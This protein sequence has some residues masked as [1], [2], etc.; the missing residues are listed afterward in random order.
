[1]RRLLIL[2]PIVL[3]ALALL[4]WQ[5]LRTEPFFV[6]G[7]IETDDIR[8][9]SRVGGRVKDVLVREGQ[10][11]KVAQSLVQL[12]PYDLEAQLAEAHARRA[13][14][15]HLLERL[16]AG[17]RPEEIAAARAERDRMAANLQKL[18]AGMRPLE[19]D[20]LVDRLDVAKA[21]LATAQRNYDRVHALYERGQATK[22]EFDEVGETLTAA[23]ARES[24]AR[25]ELELAQEGTR[26]EEIAEARAARDRAEA[27]LQLLEA[28]YRVEEIRQ[29]EADVQAADAAIAAIQRRLDELQIRA[30]LDS[31]VEVIELLPGDLIPPNAPVTTLVTPQRLYVR[32]YVPENRL[33]VQVGRM[34]SLRVDAFPQ[35]RF[36]GRVTYV[37]REAEFTPANV[38][39]PEERVKQVFRIKV[40]VLEGLDLL[41]AGM[42]ADVFLDEHHS[43]PASQ[44]AP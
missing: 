22:Q 21:E 7:I 17:P 33:D 25:H 11:V 41:R 4:Y 16:R 9:G 14:Q 38:Q 15:A 40:D 19:I 3:I 30:P 2:I 12:E 35:R 23:R 20:I 1:M 32:S 34:V 27:Q 18:Q 36:A 24:L 5:Q 10:T 39:T 43:S 29:A 8:V 31:V 28:G 37:S 13:A 44:A 6:S 26:A 42:A